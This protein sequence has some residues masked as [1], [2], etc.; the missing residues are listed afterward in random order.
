MADNDNTSEKLDLTFDA[1][2]MPDNVDQ[3]IADVRKCVIRDNE[4]E[5]ERFHPSDMERYLYTE[6]RWPLT[7]YLWQNNFSVNDTVAHVERVLEWS[8]REEIWD[9]SDA[10]FPA[11]V[12]R[13]GGIFNY[14]PDRWGHLTYYNRVRFLRPA[15]WQREATK[16]FIAHKFSQACFEAEGRGIAIIADMTGSSIFNADVTLLYYM[17]D[18]YL[19]YSPHDVRYVLLYNL[20]TI[21]SWGASI[22]RATFATKY[23]NMIQVVHGDDLF[24]FISP[25]NLPPYLG[26]TCKRNYLKVPAGCF[27]IRQGALSKRYN[28]EE[29]RRIIKHY[30]SR[31]DEAEIE[32]RQYFPDDVAAD[33]VGVG[34]GVVVGQRRT[35][36]ADV[37]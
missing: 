9:L 29:L 13:I 36:V 2:T 26:G 5:P 24:K 18:T 19:R 31:L 20:P 33:D 12:H 30:Q 1:P 34:D 28:E 3:L 35:V 10:L 27:S 8:N 15:A 16:R 6:R 11:E 21:L 32:A 14:E 7:T 17:I 25:E 37:A 22:L 4:A 23:R